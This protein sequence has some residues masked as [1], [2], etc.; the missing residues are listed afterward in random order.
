[1]AADTAA[2]AVQIRA[3]LVV[4]W[5]VVTHHRPSALGDDE[6]RERERPLSVRC[7]SLAEDPPEKPRSHR[8]F[9]PLVPR[10]ERNG[11][12]ERKTLED[13]ASGPRPVAAVR[14]GSASISPP[15][16]AS[17]GR[18][19]S[20]WPDGIQRPGCPRARGP[21]HFFPAPRPGLRLA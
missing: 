16:L 12:R 21:P 8:R 19:P 6:S 10:V 13:S 9:S 15:A 18:R 14:C 3:R 7:F 17:P 1:M 5:S 11:A 4:A 20:T 2:E